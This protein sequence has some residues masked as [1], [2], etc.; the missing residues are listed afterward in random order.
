MD[1]WM[2]MESHDV[3]NAVKFPK[4]GQMRKSKLVCIDFI[5]KYIYVSIL[6]CDFIFYTNITNIL[7]TTWGIFYIRDLSG[8]DSIPVISSSTAI[9]LTVYCFS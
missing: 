7:T 6:F 2:D 4:Q 8:T 5:L 1:G 3:Q 9:T